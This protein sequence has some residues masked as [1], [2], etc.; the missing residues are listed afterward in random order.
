MNLETKQAAIDF[1][2]AW[3]PLQ[4]AAMKRLVAKT[5]TLFLLPAIL[6][7]A[8]AATSDN[9]ERRYTE[10]ALITRLHF[11]L[12]GHVFNTLRASS[13]PS[14]SHLCLRDVRCVSTNF[15]LPRQE[16]NGVCELNGAGVL[17]GNEDHLEPEEDVVFSQYSKVK[18]RKKFITKISRCRLEW[19]ALVR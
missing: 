6:L 7:I 16:R 13:L 2:I 19:M 15:K 18:V 12:N 4:T 17:E 9:I 11:R 1:S 14:C 10:G 3:S 5:L 8:D